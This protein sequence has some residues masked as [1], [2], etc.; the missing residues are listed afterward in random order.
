MEQ[1]VSLCARLNVGWSG[2]AFN[3]MNHIA[4]SPLF[5]HLGKQ[6]SGLQV[7]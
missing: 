6:I 5:Y 4:K 7:V 2:T 3:T 1:A